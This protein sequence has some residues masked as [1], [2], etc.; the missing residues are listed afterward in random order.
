MTPAMY[1][2]FVSFVGLIVLKKNLSMDTKNAKARI[3]I[4]LKT[5]FSVLTIVPRFNILIKKSIIRKKESDYSL[6]S[7][8][9]PVETLMVSTSRF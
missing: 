3:Q 7:S 1:F 4:S 9:Y 5:Y 2:I 8:L 6:S